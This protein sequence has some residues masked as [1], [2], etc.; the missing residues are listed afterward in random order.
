MQKLA[1]TDQLDS[2]A[3]QRVAQFGFATAL[4]T[5]AIGASPAAVRKATEKFAAVMKANAERHDAILHM[6][7]EFAHAP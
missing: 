5:P 1:S 7:F 6:L 3:L 2:A 4:A